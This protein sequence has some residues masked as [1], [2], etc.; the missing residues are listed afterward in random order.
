MEKEIL[1]LILY[2]LFTVLFAIL[3]IKVT[4]KE[5]QRICMLSLFLWLLCT[6]CKGI[7]ILF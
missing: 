4:Y 3:S 7:V 5:T 1:E 2:L 6:I